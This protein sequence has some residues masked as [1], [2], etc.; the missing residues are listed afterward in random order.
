MN[1][2][3][4]Q[5]LNNSVDTLIYLFILL[6]LLRILNILTE[7]HNIYMIMKIRFRDASLAIFLSRNSEQ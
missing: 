5:T 3:I 2:V 7:N 4:Y 1:N 6:K